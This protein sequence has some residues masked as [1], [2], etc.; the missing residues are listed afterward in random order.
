MAD[1][2]TM[3]RRLEDMLMGTDW[4]GSL[5]KS[6]GSSWVHWS[7]EDE[8]GK[9]IAVGRRTDPEECITDMCAAVARLKNGSAS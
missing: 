8:T 4:C 1:F 6:G 2:D 5:S 3:W 9:C 7:V